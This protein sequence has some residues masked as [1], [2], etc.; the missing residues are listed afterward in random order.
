MRLNR[1]KNA[2]I[3]GPDK[4]YNLSDIFRRLTDPTTRAGAAG[5]AAAAPSAPKPT[6]QS[7]PAVDLADLFSAGGAVSAAS[8]RE[9][10]FEGAA[11]GAAV[12]DI[13]VS[14]GPGGNADWEDFG[15]AGEDFGE[16]QFVSADTSEVKLVSDVLV[17]G[18]DLLDSAAPA[19]GDGSLGTGTGADNGPATFREAVEGLGSEMFGS[20]WGSFGGANAHDPLDGGGLCVWMS[21]LVF[22]YAD[23]HLCLSL[24]VPVSL[25]LLSLSTSLSLSRFP[26]LSLCPSLCIQASALW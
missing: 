7:A 24:I 21:V 23:L 17:P 22:M 3:F 12:P 20:D 25:C 15:G 11:Q 5:A 13:A 4:R 8:A 10:L 1:G 2:I 6:Q 16:F 18:G 19:P 14:D 26:V 9:T